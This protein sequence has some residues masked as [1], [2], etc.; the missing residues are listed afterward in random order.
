MSWTLTVTD[1]N[2]YVRRSLAGDPIL[3]SVTIK[4]EISNFKRHSSGHL[5]FSLKDEK[6]RIQCVMFRQYAMDVRFLPKD[7]A[8]VRLTGS[9][10]LYVQSGT[11][12]FYAQSMLEE[13]T[14]SKHLL[15]EELKKKLMQQGLFDLGRKRPLPLLPKMVGVA[16]AKTGA[17]IHD[18]MQVVARRN[19]GVQLVL[20]PCQVQGEG[21]AA[22]IV[23]S[24]EALQK[25]KGIDV[26]IVGRGGGSIE[27]LWAFNEEIVVR[28]IYRSSIPVISAVGHETDT[29]LSDLVAD[30]RAAT[31]SVAGELAVPQQLSLQ[32]TI[33]DAH[34]R[35][36][37]ALKQTLLYY[38]NQLAMMEK[39][40]NE[41]HP[42]TKI[43]KMQN[44]VSSL[45]EKQS[46]NV[47]NQLVTHKTKV[48]VL[49]KKLQALGPKSVLS[50]GYAL[51]MEKGKPIKS[52]EQMP[53]EAIVHFVDGSVTVQTIA[54]ERGN[55]FGEERKEF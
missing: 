2:D 32:K 27:D 4:G 25:V 46:Q 35:L 7:G 22:D 52:V 38:K 30:V 54:V 45:L 18:I 12:Q 23:R 1:L 21:A 20:S 50:R 26:I 10:S 33:S 44:K 15:Y 11:Y 3:Q 14:G 34:M 6:S 43:L 53:K 31:P 9:V 39:R 49:E 41:L 51:V 37:N 24:I 28:A 13:G 19:P 16:T 17:V 29:T 8:S 36:E 5:Y 55:C 40:L 47:Y 42:H 48:M